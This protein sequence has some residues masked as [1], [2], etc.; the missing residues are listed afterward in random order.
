MKRRFGYARL[1]CLALLIG[2]AAALFAMLIGTLMGIASGHF[3]GL[4]GGALSRLTE[5][6]LVI[7]FLP[8]AIYAERP[9]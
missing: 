3:T 9:H 5:W 2:F 4:T 1:A 6:F 7:P 8:L